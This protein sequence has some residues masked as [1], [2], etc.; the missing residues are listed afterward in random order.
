MSRNEDSEVLFSETTGLATG[1]S[2]SITLD[3]L[4]IN[5]MLLFR[6]SSEIG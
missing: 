1:T 5:L 2:E 6:I 3:F 4:R